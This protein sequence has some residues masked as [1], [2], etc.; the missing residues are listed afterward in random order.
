MSA[1]P[2]QAKLG[3]GMVGAKK[4]FFFVS[5][6]LEICFRLLK[7]SSSIKYVFEK[8]LHVADRSFPQIGP[9]AKI[10]QLERECVWYQKRSSSQHD[11]WCTCLCWYGMRPAL[12]QPWMF[13]EWRTELAGMLDGR[14]KRWRK[15]CIS[16]DCVLGAGNWFDGHKYVSR[17]PVG[18]FNKTGGHLNKK[19][20]CRNMGFNL[21]D[22]YVTSMGPF[23]R[24]LPAFLRSH[25][26]W[27]LTHIEKEIGPVPFLFFLSFFSSWAYH[28]ADPQNQSGSQEARLRKDPGAFS[29]AWAAHVMYVHITTCDW[30]GFSHPFLLERKV[31]VDI[32]L[33]SK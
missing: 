24:R 19:K 33:M 10:K 6:S 2:Q 16:H 1:L 23:S 20:P 22:M 27:P 21:M 8:L 3:F 15:A 26:I 25:H 4:I 5:L 30:K 31:S 32:K 13:G 28:H 11:Y 17:Y 14:E 7:T 29:A 9:W 18:R 12:A